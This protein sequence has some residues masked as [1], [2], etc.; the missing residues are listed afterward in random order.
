MPRNPPPDSRPQA[1]GKV[2]G[3]PGG[4]L[5]YAG[6][7]VDI[8]AGDALVER[9]KPLCAKTLRAEVI[10]GVGG[11]AGLFKLSAAKYRSP[12]LVAATDGVGTK[13]KLAGEL[14]VHGGIGTDLVAMCVNDVL[15]HGAEPLFFLDYFACGKLSVEAAAAVI[16]GIAGGC[17]LAGCALIGGETAE[18][19][20]MYA[21]GEYD[22]AGFTVGVAEEDALCGAHRVENGDAVIALASSGVHANGF[23]LVRKV[24]ADSGADL[25]RPFGG[26][27][28]GEALLAPTHIYVKALLP[29]ILQGK[30]HALAHVTGGGLSGNL[31]RM[32]GADQAASVDLGSWS[33]PA[34]FEWIRETGR[35]EE[36]EMLRVFNCGVGMAAAVAPGEAEALIR[37]I[38]DAGFEAWQLGE[39]IPRRGQAPVAYG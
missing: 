15:T 3:A 12:V 17:E 22:L 4:A 30:V 39:I 31:P 35:I 28:L 18:M 36:A 27:T 21:G 25:A 8:T 33:R 2:A 23:A 7:G 24:I 26:A 37:Q 10:G 14:G 38:Q 34:V 32:L 11:F 1:P 16:A 5:D 13:L 9:I 20:G 29:A 6:A 19:P